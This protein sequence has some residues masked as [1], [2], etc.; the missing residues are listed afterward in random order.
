MA[1]P[2]E[3][4]ALARLLL[5]GAATTAVQSLL[6]RAFL[7]AFGGDEAVL[8]GLLGA[9]LAAGALGAAAGRTRP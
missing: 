9:W 2:A 4:R 7:A 6:A 1:A 5:L 3:R 8:A